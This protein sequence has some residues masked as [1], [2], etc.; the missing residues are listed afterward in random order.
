MAARTVREAMHDGCECILG[1][2]REIAA[3]PPQHF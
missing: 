3:K 2:M 1:V